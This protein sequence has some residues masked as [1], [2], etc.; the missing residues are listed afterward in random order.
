MPVRSVFVDGESGPYWILGWGQPYQK[1]RPWGL[2]VVQY[3]LPWSLSSA[4]WAVSQSLLS[5]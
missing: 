2:R 5:V 1:D 4:I 3:Q